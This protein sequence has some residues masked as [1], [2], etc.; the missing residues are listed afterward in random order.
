L[1][2]L[3]SDM[4]HEGPL[5][6]D[7]K[8]GDAGT[9]LAH[10]ASGGVLSR[11]PLVVWDGGLGEYAPLPDA[12]FQGG[13]D[14]PA[15]AHDQQECH[16]PRGFLESAR[17]SQHAGLVAKPNAVVPRLLPFIAVQQCLGW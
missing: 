10:P 12:S 5:P 8:H 6:R 14:E 13:I 1:A 7:P 9:G 3:I 2:L 11:L 15:H 4:A 16:E 17:S